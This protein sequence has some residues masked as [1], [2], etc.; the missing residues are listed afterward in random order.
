VTVPWGSGFGA[1]ITAVVLASTSIAVVLLAG[2]LLTLDRRSSRVMLQS[3][4]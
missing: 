3:R 2:A 4:L 1:K